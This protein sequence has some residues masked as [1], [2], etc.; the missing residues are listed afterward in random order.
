MN[1]FIT[2][3]AQAKLKC[4]IKSTQAK[5]IRLSSTLGQINIEIIDVGPS[6]NDIV[7]NNNPPILTDRKTFNILGNACV[8]FCYRTNDFIFSRNA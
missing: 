7:I 6:V 4:I 5:G 2:Y 8:D 3:C 1:K